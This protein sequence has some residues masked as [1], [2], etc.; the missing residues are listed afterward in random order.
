MTDRASR[1]KAIYERH[2]TKLAN[3]NHGRY[4]SIE[5]DS[6]DFPLR[7]SVAAAPPLSI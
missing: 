1:A 3:E 2:K 4:V 5:P 6:G 7:A